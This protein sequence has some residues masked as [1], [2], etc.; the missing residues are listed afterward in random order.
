MKNSFQTYGA[1]V[2]GTAFLTFTV[3]IALTHSLPVPTPLLAGITLG[4]LVYVI[5]PVSGAQVNPA[6]TI[7]LWSVGKMKPLVTVKYIIAQ[8]VGAVFALELFLLLGGILPNVPAQNS[9]VTGV[10]EA[11]GAGVLVTGVSAVVY[12]M[13]KETSTGLTVGTA[14]FLGALLAS[15]MGNGIVNPAVAFGVGAWSLPYLVGPLLGGVIAAAVYR[16]IIGK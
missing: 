9:L 15:S 11:L 4:F 6:V 14:L 1:E 3:L 8:I 16:W 7:G 12:G 13:A 10:G 5:G 2:L